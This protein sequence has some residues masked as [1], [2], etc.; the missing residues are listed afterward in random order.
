MPDSPVPY[1]I[2]ESGISLSTVFFKC[3]Y[4]ELHGEYS[5]LLRGIQLTPGTQ[6]PQSYLC[7]SVC[8]CGLFIPLQRNLSCHF[9]SF[10]GQLLTTAN[11]ESA[12]LFVFISVHLWTVHSAS[13]ESF[14]PFRVLSW[15]AYNHGVH[16]VH[17]EVSFIRCAFCGRCGLF[18]WAQPTFRFSGIIRAISCAFVANF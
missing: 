7:L 9:V 1:L 12:E 3:C 2:R 13:A 16:S 8:I 11:A 15:P 18:L 4:T 14:V 17:R 6:R 5:E 10:R